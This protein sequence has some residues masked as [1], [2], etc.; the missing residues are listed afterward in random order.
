MIGVECSNHVA[1][2]WNS[3]ET[4]LYGNTLPMKRCEDNVQSIAIV[5][6][7]LT[8]GKLLVVTKMLDAVS[9]WHSISGNIPCYSGKALAKNRAGVMPRKST[10]AK[11][12]NS[13]Q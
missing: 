13:V 5:K 6:C 10:M 9:A 8:V 2:T 4:P 12:H 3:L 1:V 11:Y 7:T